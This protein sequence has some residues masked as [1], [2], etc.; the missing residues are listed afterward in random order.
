MSKGIVISWSGVRTKELAMV[1]IL[2]KRKHSITWFGVISPDV[3]FVIGKCVDLFPCN[4]ADC[5]PFKPKGNRV[6]LCTCKFIFELERFHLAISSRE[7]LRL[8]NDDL[9][10]CFE[11]W[12]GRLLRKRCLQIICRGYVS[13]FAKDE[14]N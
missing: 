10:Y 9:L 7:Y 1:G 8:I 12:R 5:R 4:S 2:E 3:L 11:G 13:T 6:L 14:L